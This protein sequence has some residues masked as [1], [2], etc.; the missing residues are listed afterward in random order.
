M[1][2]DDRIANLAR[3]IHAARRREHRTKT[4]DQIVA[5]RRRGACELH[6]ICAN[7]VTSVNSR[8]PEEGLILSSPSYAP[9]MFRNCGANLIQIGSGDRVIDIAFQATHDL[10]DT[11]R[12]LVPYVLEGEIRAFNQ[13]MLDRFEVRSQLLFFCLEQDDASWRFSD[14]RTGHTGVFG[15]NLLLNFMEGLFI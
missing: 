4:A 1:A 15:G 10:F 3:Q 14:W 8:L 11:E 7:F 13:K 5:L 2:Q 12:F 6:S 9:E